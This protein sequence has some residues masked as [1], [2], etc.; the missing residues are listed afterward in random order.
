MQLTST[1]KSA[2]RRPR[3]RRRRAGGQDG[4]YRTDNLRWHIDPKNVNCWPGSGST[5]YDLTSN[6]LDFAKKGSPTYDA[7]DG[8]FAYD[9]TND[10]WVA[11][12][13]SNCLHKFRSGNSAEEEWTIEFWIKYGVDD[14]NQRTFL[15]KLF[16]TDFNTAN[17]NNSQISWRIKGDGTQSLWNRIVKQKGTTNYENVFIQDVNDW[18][19]TDGEW[20]H[21]VMLYDYQ[22]S[23]NTVKSYLNGDTSTV[24]NLLSN[25]GFDNKDGLNCQLGPEGPW[26]IGCAWRNADNSLYGNTFLGNIGIIRYYADVISTSDIEGNYAAEKWRYGH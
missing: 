21:V 25:G 7:S 12:N 6:N 9:G 18:S 3:R 8:S 22:N 17:T 15:S 19:V 23:T 1:R 16:P 5:L 14:G 26:G 11:P 13:N 20:T 24:F 2:I 4:P 10:G